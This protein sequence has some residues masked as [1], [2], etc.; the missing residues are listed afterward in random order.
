MI[1]TLRMAP[2]LVGIY[3]YS[4]KDTLYQERP[5]VLIDQRTTIPP[6]RFMILLRY[7]IPFE[8]SF[9]K[10]SRTLQYGHSGG[11]DV[12]LAMSEIHPDR[13]DGTNC[14]CAHTPVWLMNSGLDGGFALKALLA[15]EL[16]IVDLPTDLSA[17]TAAWRQVINAAQQ[18]PLGRARIA[19][20]TTL[21]Q[22]P[23]WVSSTTPEPDPTM[24]TRFSR[25][26]L[27]LLSRGLRSQVV[28]GG[29]CLSIVPLGQWSGN[30]D[31]DYKKFFQNGDEFYKRAVRRLYRD[32]GANLDADLERIKAFPRIAADANAVK[33]NAV[34][35]WTRRGARYV[36]NRKFPSFAS[37][38]TGMVP[39]PLA[40]SRV[41]TPRYAISV[42]QSFTGRRSSTGRA[43][44]LFSVAEAAAAIE[45]SS[46]GWITASGRALTQLISIAWGIRWIQRA[47]RATTI[48]SNSSTTVVGF[49]R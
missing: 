28:N 27:N 22:L 12:A 35:W 2:M 13:I 24:C 42:T 32:A 31:V 41:M 49:R 9:G 16:P 45:T 37:T 6:T 30:T 18:T 7:S 11:G 34:K 46:S 20:A 1:C 44:V 21:G 4:I 15:P 17:I 8:A 47:P 10:P 23:A 43:T 36:A 40:W 33:C 25:A 38:P 14:R 39:F 26:C 19:L 3:T 29:S 48:T 5:G